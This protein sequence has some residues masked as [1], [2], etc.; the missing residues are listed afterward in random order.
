MRLRGTRSEWQH[1]AAVGADGPK[2]RR[3]AGRVGPIERAVKW[4]GCSDSGPGDSV[5]FQHKLLSPL[6]AREGHAHT[7]DGPSFLILREVRGV[8]RPVELS[9]AECPAL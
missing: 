3:V 7:L 9:K 5:H 6:M 1:I 4:I 8:G 2:R